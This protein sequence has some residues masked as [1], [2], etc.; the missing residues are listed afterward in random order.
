[1]SNSI[2]RT[3]DSHIQNLHF[4]IILYYNFNLYYLISWYIM[5]YFI[6]YSNLQQITLSDTKT[7]IYHYFII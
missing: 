7:T 5:Y 6:L 2:F 4:I 1:M 3:P